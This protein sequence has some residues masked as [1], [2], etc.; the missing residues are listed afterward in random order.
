MG[1]V[2]DRMKHHLGGNNKKK[3]LTDEYS[4]ADIQ[5]K[6]NNIPDLTPMEKKVI[7]S[8]WKSIKKKYD[9]VKILLKRSNF[10]ETPA[11]LA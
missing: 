6:F 9:E 1:N 5:K 11:I 3:P 8:S 7:R 4:P 10:C 2:A